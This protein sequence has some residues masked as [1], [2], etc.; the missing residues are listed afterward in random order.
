MGNLGGCLGY[1]RMVGETLEERSR[2]ISCIVSVASA[3]L[4]SFLGWMALGVLM[5]LVVALAVE[6]LPPRK[7]AAQ[8]DA[9]ERLR[10]LEPALREC[11]G[12]SATV[13][14]G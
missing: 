4:V 11:L 10:L 3:S 6:K 2:G 5:H 14:L 1:S 9:L 8:N 13:A 12:A 7:R